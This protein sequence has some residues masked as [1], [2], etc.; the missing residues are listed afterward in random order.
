MCIVDHFSLDFAYSY[1]SLLVAGS[2]DNTHTLPLSGLLLE[3]LMREQLLKT[4]RE[5]GAGI[6]FSIKR[7]KLIVGWVASAGTIPFFNFT[8]ISL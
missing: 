4:P 6:S 3:H 1:L 5:V 2:V 7:D 8:L